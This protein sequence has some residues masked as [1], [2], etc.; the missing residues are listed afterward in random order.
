MSNREMIK[1]LNPRCQPSSRE[2]LSNTLIPAWYAVEKENV[3]REFRNVAVTGDRWTSVAQDHY[4]TVSWYHE[5]ENPAYQGS[6]HLSQ[7]GNVKAED[8]GDILDKF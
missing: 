5:G 3:K 8:M 4:F 1:A 2:M 7:T 6:V